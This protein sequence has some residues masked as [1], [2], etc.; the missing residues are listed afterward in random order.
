MDIDR[1]N[2]FIDAAQTLSFSVTAQHL[3]VTQ[4]TVSKYIRDL[5]HNFGVVLFDRSATGLK[6]TE[7]GTAILP[8]ARR[9]V[10][11]CGKLEDM[12]KSLEGDVIGKLRIACT[13][14]A[15]KYILPKL[16]ARFRHR[17]PQVQISILSCTQEN[18]VERLLEEDADLGVVSYE[19]GAS[20]LDCQY[21]FTDHIVMIVPTNHPWAMRKY[22]EPADL[23]E[24]Q[25]I[26]REETSG[27]RRALL[28]ELTMHDITLDDLNVFLEVGNAEAIVSTVG[29][30]IGIS[31][32]SRMSAAYALASKCVVEVPVQGL[33]IRRKICM[34]RQSMHQS[35]RAQDVFWGFIHD[36][37]NDDL[38]KLVS[39]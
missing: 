16:A 7:A 36:P 33:D 20:G 18:A 14:A 23:L 9:L 34:M 38:Y 19:V 10:R 37:V 31:F 1:L 24:E 30:G 15:G 35:N 25:L 26:M 21:F 28:S 11:E 29:A 22:I 27:T 2:A 4:P 32:V 6:L 8:W 12:A 39:T 17:H 3:H 5:E 13:T